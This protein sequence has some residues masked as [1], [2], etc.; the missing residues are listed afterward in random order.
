MAKCV[1]TLAMAWLRS[2]ATQSAGAEEEPVNRF[3][4]SDIGTRS[5]D[6]Q[7]QRSPSPERTRATGSRSIF[8]PAKVTDSPHQNREQHPTNRSTCGD[9]NE[10]KDAHAELVSCV[11]GFG[12]FYDLIALP[13]C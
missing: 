1:A 11:I 9:K 4:F 3:A 12:S 7:P 8:E 2:V 6:P 13:Y 10:P 5:S